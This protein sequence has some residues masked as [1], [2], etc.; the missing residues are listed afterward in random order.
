M[1]IILTCANCSKRVQAPDALAGRK[2]KC[3]NCGRVLEVPPARP[4][5]GQSGAAPPERPK[6]SRPADVL[7]GADPM[8]EL[9]R[10]L[11][12]A[13]VARTNLPA[14]ARPAVPAD[15]KPSVAPTTG[16]RFE[17]VKAQTGEAATGPA[18]PLLAAP[19]PK[20]ESDELIAVP[21]VGVQTP[22]GLS[23]RERKAAA[24]A[25]RWQR[26]MASAARTIG[27]V[28]AAVCVILG[29]AAMLLMTY[30][31]REAWWLVPAVGA[32]VFM[33]VLAALAALG[34]LMARHVLLLLAD[35]SEETRRQKEL[36]DR[37]G[38]R[39]D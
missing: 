29:A 4:S 9:A 22:S 13:T 20:P 11:E 3:P 12:E 21:P 33:L 24:Q 14:A 39:L 25:Y 15:T 16:P 31:G 2:V 28:L 36:L 7:P 37:I 35:L 27:F 32:F 34:G 23:T 6:D 18:A 5:A 10:A 30:Q 17:T 1:A 19:S 8:T 38:E 26:T